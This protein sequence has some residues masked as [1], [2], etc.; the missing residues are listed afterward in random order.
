MRLIAQG[1]AIKGAL[2]S[3]SFACVGL[4]FPSGTSLVQR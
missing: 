3:R 2:E 1:L 4:P